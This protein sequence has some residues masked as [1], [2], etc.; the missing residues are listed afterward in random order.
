MRRRT[1]AAGTAAVI[2]ALA[3]SAAPAHADGAECRDTAREARCAAAAE[4]SP[5]TIS[6]TSRPMP[7]ATAPAPAVPAPDASGPVAPTR[8]VRG[9]VGGAANSGPSDHDVGIGLTFVLGAALAAGYVIRWR[10]RR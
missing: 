7:T 6:A 5:P 3:L 2:A 1:G 10:R 9:G 8:G 4:T